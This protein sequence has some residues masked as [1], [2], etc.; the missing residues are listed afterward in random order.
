MNK[1]NLLAASV[2]LLGSL[3]AFSSCHGTNA[4]ENKDSSIKEVQYM[5]ATSH[6]EWV[7]FSFAT[8]KEV[9]PADP[10]K[11]QS[12]DIAFRRE[13]LAP[14]AAVHYTG[15]GG[16][17][18]TDVKDI[19]KA[20]KIDAKKLTYVGNTAVERK[21]GGMGPK[22]DVTLYYAHEKIGEGS[23]GYIVNKYATYDIHMGN[24]QGGNSKAMYPPVKDVYVVR[25]ADGKRYYALLITDSVNAEGKNGGTLSFKY[26]QI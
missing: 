11:D 9:K 13:N 18:R 26:R 25:S 5:N 12:W 3:V 21:V 7:Y 24:M 20:D 10:T 1:K 14:N 6:T 17:A 4:P 19:T 15:K 22:K 8:G 23:M 2:L 16:I